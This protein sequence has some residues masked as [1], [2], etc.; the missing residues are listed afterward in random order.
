M[1]YPLA[2]TGALIAAAFAK[3]P[4][5]LAVCN[6]YMCM[7]NVLYVSL[8]GALNFWYTASHACVPGGPA[9]SMTYY[10]TFAGAVAA[11]STIVGVALFNKYM[12]AWPFR[13]MFRFTALLRCCGAVADIIIINRWNL[14]W[15]IPDE[16]MFV[17]GNAVVGPIIAAM[18]AIPMVALTAKL[19]PENEEGSVY[20]MLAAF[21]NFGAAA[22]SALGVAFA[23]YGGVSL[24]NDGHHCSYEHLSPLVVVCNMLLPMLILSL[25][26]I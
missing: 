16:I 24:R 21:Q 18:D 10:I 19:C 7:S 14:A 17:F 8:A 4:R 1:L 6:A 23:H 22:A 12:A 25:I 2:A 11:L 3:L 13:D 9:F 20:A 26:H 5:E 15:H